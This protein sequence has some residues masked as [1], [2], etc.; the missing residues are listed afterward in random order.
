MFGENRVHRLAQL[1]D[2]FSVYD[3]HLEDPFRLT[4]SEVLQHHIFDVL[5]SKRVEVEHAGD[6]KFGRLSFGFPAAFVIHVAI[7]RL[8][9]TGRRKWDR[10]LQRNLR[11]GLLQGPDA[12]FLEVE[13]RFVVVVL[14]THATVFWTCSP[15]KL[16]E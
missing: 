4:F 15:L 1:S 9:R 3:P 8:I 7:G 2:S 13:V 12:D 11:T 5:R 16:H 14:K 10:E 6:W